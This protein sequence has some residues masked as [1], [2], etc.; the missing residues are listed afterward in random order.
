MEPL[1]SPNDNVAAGTVVTRYRARWT[2]F[3]VLVAAV[4]IT[5]DQ[6]T[7]QWALHNLTE[8]TPVPVFGEALQWMLMFNS[9]AAF[10]FLSNATWLFTTVSSLV[11][12]V[13]AFYLRKAQSTVWAVVAGLVLGG[14]LGNVLDRFFREPGFAQ[15]H[16]VDF[17][18]TPWML[19]AIYNVADI[20]VVS[21][22]G[23]FLICM[24]LGVGFD[25]KREPRERQAADATTETTHT[26]PESGLE[27]R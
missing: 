12:V 24:L 25:G 18:Y 23:L 20:A 13:I 4:V 6:V 2:V 27:Q 17:V 26:D 22:M 14:A 16:V 9:G 19:P 1:A 7:K 15:G 8:G 10:S 5:T 11:V 21:G 3:A